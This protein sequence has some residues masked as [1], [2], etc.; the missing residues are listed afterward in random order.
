MPDIPRRE[1]ITQAGAA[2]AGLA[3]FSA[4]QP[5]LAETPLNMVRPALGEAVDPNSSRRNRTMKRYVIEREIAGIGGKTAAECSL[6]AATS[7]AALAQLSPRIQWEHSYFTANKTFC[8]YLA[9]DEEAIRKHSEISGFP[10]NTITLVTG[11]V[12][13]TTAV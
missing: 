2:L 3:A 13:P 12:D 1:F 4:V 7:N 5:A 10:A 6:I 8:I 9:E 11:M